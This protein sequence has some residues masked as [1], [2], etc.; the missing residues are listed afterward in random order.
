MENSGRPP[1]LISEEL[2]FDCQ[3]A[4]YLLSS[5]SN[6]SWEDLVMEELGV[7]VAKEKKKAGQ[8]ALVF[9]ED[10]KAIKQICRKSGV[11]FRTQE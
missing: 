8:A 3:I 11:Q 5:G 9:Q 2:S 7:M 4:A 1:V 10:E 6:F